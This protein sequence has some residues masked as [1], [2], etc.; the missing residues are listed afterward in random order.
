MEN[1]L[2]FILG[3][4]LI[5]LGIY[6]CSYERKKFVSQR[7]KEEYIRMSFTVEFIVGAFT[8]FAI[9]IKLIF[10]SI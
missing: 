5:I 2:T 10:D 8:L 7:K 9:G 4:L 1:V 6:W 3:A